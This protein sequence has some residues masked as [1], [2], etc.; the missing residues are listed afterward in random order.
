MDLLTRSLSGSFS[1]VRRR[2]FVPGNSLGNPAAQILQ[3]TAAPAKTAN[4]SH[5]AP[6]HRWSKGVSFVSTPMSTYIERN[7]VARV[8]P[9]TKPR[10]SINIFL[11]QN[12]I[13]QKL[14][15]LE[16]QTVIIKNM[17]DKIR[18]HVLEVIFIYMIFKTLLGL[19]GHVVMA[20]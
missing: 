20:T 3:N 16:T 19:W 15:V 12:V 11:F 5:Q 9:I 10:S 17:A 8:V 2:Y 6:T 18:F 13:N 7:T 4:P 1:M 14:F